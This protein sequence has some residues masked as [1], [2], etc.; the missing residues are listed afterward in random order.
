MSFIKNDNTSRVYAPGYFLADNEHCER[1]TREITD[2]DARVITV[3]GGGKFMPM[4]TIY[5]TNDSNAE[6]IVYEDVDVTTGSM[7]GS[8][9]L[10]GSV[11]SDR[12]YDEI[13][14]EARTA[15]KAKG[16]KF[17]TEP[18]VTRPDVVESSGSIIHD[19]DMQP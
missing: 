7:P 19:D 3:N 18:T 13:S 12:L 14:E 2:S 17:I 1:K 4:G 8:V 11:Y 10:N 5:P 16:F 6:G 15:L 9:V